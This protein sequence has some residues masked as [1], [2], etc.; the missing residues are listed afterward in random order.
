[1]E[2]RKVNTWDHQIAR[3]IYGR[4]KYPEPCTGQWEQCTGNVKQSHFPRTDRECGGCAFIRKMVPTDKTSCLRTHHRANLTSCTWTFNNLN[5]LVVLWALWNHIYFFPNYVVSFLFTWQICFAY[6]SISALHR[7]C[8]TTSQTTCSAMNKRVPKSKRE[9]AV[10]E[11]KGLRLVRVIRFSDKQPPA[12][13]HLL[14][15][16]FVQKSSSYSPRDI[17]ALYLPPPLT[18]LQTVW[19]WRVT[20]SEVQFASN[21]SVMGAVTSR[22]S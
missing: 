20:Q 14:S 17:L 15:V 9:V 4:W 3:K 22:S 1:M 11:E 18:K 12:F 7:G 8:P 5:K 16:T 10:M 21:T 2:V 19:N 13:P 6:F